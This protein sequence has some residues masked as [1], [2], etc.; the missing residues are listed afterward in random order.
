MRGLILSLVVGCLLIGVDKASA[1]VGEPFTATDIIRLLAEGMPEPRVVVLVAESCVQAGASESV[2][3]MLV[4]AG[5]G[6]ALLRVVAAVP[7]P[8]EELASSV[9]FLSLPEALEEGEA[10]QV[11]VLVLDGQGGEL[12]GREALWSV[13]DESVLAISSTG[14]LRGLQAGRAELRVA[15][16]T[17]RA[18]AE[19]RVLGVPESV[20]VDPSRL[21]LV[22]GEELPIRVIVRDRA[23][24]ELR[25]EAQ[26][27]PADPGIAM[28]K[29]G[30]VLGVGVG[31]TTLIIFQVGLS[32][33]R[34]PVTV[35]EGAANP[36][37]DDDVSRP[38][39][40]V[41]FGDEQFSLIPAG[42]FRMGSE[43]GRDNERPVHTVTLTRSF[44]M[45]RT[46]VTQGQWREIMGTNPSGFSDCGDMC[47][48]ETVSWGE[49]QAFIRALNERY[50][51]RNYRLPTEAEWEYAARAGTTGD[52]G[53]TG[54]TGRDGVV[55]G[56][57]RRPDAPGG[58]EAAK[59]VGPLRYA[60]EC[61]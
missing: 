45:Q 30:R 35:R 51:G 43:N 17:V 29:D 42:T 26:K 5:A 24:N 13:S 61:V 60:R 21:N 44:Y 46:P 34:I 11:G 54:G 33:E 1:Q 9:R 4:E 3:R 8:E 27:V 36:W 41:G 10:V 38:Q 15:V 12:G 40:G 19:V 7:C 57:F 25:H 39:L 58:L 52:Y 18:I 20:E 56:Q 50:P 32:P 47:P 49:A 23:G 48:V 2:Q 16:D 6:Q 31:E 22:I 14:E 37:T 55:R 28:V 59:C 53:G